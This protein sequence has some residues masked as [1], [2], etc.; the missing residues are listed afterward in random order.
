MNKKTLTWIIV[1]V[2]AVIAIVWIIVAV[3]SGNNQNG[4][5]GG[6]GGGNLNQSSEITDTSVEGDVV[7]GS[8]IVV[9]NLEEGALGARITVVNAGDTKQ[10]HIIKATFFDADG[11]E[12]ATGDAAATLEPGEEKESILAID[13]DWEGYA[14]VTYAI[15][16]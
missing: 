16:D 10:N 2:V 7:E 1:A 9:T 3:N 6:N 4:G 15:G 13:G 5:N 14:S 8:S 12:I 11:N